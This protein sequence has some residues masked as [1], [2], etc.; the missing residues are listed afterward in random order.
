M[1]HIKF[2]PKVENTKEPIDN[3]PLWKKYSFISGE[4]LLK[5]YENQQNNGDIS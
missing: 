1:K 5:F 2:N 3:L 4:D